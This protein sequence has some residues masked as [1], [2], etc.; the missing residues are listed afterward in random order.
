MNL[1]FAGSLYGYRC[2]QFEIVAIGLW[3]AGSR[4]GAGNGNIRHDS[5]NSDSSRPVRFFYS[6]SFIG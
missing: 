3:M 6:S 5:E 1:V 4:S 2:V